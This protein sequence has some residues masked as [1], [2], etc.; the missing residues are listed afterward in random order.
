[1]RFSSDNAYNPQ[2]HPYIQQVKQSIEI[3]K[4]KQALEEARYLPDLHLGISNQSIQGI[5]A[6]NILYPMSRRFTSFTVG[7]G[8]PHPFGAQQAIIEASKTSVKI[9]ETEYEFQ[10]KKISSE[11]KAAKIA[12]DST[13]QT[14]RNIEL[15]Q[16]PLIKSVREAAEIQYKTGEISYLEWTLAMHHTITI[17]SQY[18]DV[19]QQYYDLSNTV[20]Y[21]EEQ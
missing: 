12:R 17:Q 20:T 18:Y 6:D 1:M 11:L 10:V 4:A 16:L 21:L 13:L 14:V 2:M 3:A 8:I 19:L 9:S 7:V 5:G 15:H